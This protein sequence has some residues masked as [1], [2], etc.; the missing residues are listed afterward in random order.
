[1]SGF[2]GIEG[3]AASEGPLFRSQEEN[4]NRVR[5]GLNFLLLYQTFALALSSAFNTEVYHVLFRCLLCQL[6]LEPK[7]FS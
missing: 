1:M 3:E 7:T 4:K 6:H 2:Q 5:I